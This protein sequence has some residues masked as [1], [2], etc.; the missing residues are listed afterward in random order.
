MSGK[1]LV[2]ISLKTGDEATARMRW[3]QIHP[4]VEALVQIARVSANGA[5]APKQAPVQVDRLT[6][7]QISIMGAQ[8]H[9]DILYEH[10]RTWVDPTF[11]PPVTTVIT[12]LMLAKGAAMNRERPRT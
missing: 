2:K 12:K 1:P 5:S 9:H 6:R 11:S 7:D 3:V 10:D 8:A 4:Q